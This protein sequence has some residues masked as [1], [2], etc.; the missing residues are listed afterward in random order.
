MKKLLS[1]CELFYK[2]FLK[3]KMEKTNFRKFVLKQKYVIIA[4]W[5]ELPNDKVIVIADNTIG[6]ATAESY[7]M[8]VSRNKNF[9]SIAYVHKNTVY[10]VYIPIYYL[11]RNSMKAVT[12]FGKTICF[13]CGDTS[14]HVCT[15]CALTHWCSK[16]C[17]HRDSEHVK[18]CEGVY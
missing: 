11:M 5:L 10:P 3:D 9:I 8:G 16:N 4:K 12:V 6:A 18:L 17:K 13:V 15:G 14:T 7:G 2:L 1:A